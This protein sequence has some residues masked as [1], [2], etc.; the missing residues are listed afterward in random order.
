MLALLPP[1]SSVTPLDLGGRTG[2]HLFADFGGPGEDDL[3]D[4]GVG[5]EPLPHHRA[6]PGQHLQQVFVQPGF[7]RQLTEPDGGQRGPL[8]GFDQHGVAGGQGRRDAPG[9]D[10][11]REVPRRDHPDH[12]QWFVERD[13]QAAGHG[14]LLAGQAF[15]AGGVE[16]Q[17]VANVAG[18]PFGRPDGVPGIGDLERGQL[19]DVGV[20]RGRECAQPGR[21]FG[22]RQ[23]RPPPLGRLSPPHRVVDGGDIGVLDRPQHLLG[24][25]VDQLSGAHQAHRSA[26]DR[27][28]STTAAN[29]RRS[30]RDFSGCH[31]TA[32]TK[33]SPGSSSASTTP[34][35][36]HALTTRDSPTL[37][38]A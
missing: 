14:N 6:L 11:H 7:H 28:A 5:D 32:S 13:V 18:L 15:R 33:P 30:S 23:P 1:S 22:R 31:C 34:S 8:G 35:A 4:S 37:S 3:A 2:H 19:V 9:R 24:G 38:M 21:A 17:H 25:G 36:S 27:A 26:Y 20:D 10:H 29:S 16:R 12:T